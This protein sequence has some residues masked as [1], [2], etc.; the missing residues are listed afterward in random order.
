MQTIGKVAKQLN[1]N[2]ETIRYYERLGLIQQPIK[3]DSGFRIYDQ[4]LLK[5]LTFILKAKALGFTLKEIQS[6]LDLSQNCQQVESLGLI[7]LKLISEKIEQLQQ[8]ELVI[9]N[10]TTSCQS[11]QNKQQCPVIESLNQ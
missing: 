10:L 1:I 9:E 7:K 11:N 2:S 6:L 8:L 3:P 4:T 5:R